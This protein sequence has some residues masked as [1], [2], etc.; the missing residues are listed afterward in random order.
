MIRIS[1][2]PDDE[3]PH[4]IL[5][6]VDKGAQDK[7]A[8][9]A[10]ALNTPRTPRGQKKRPEKIV[11]D[12]GLTVETHS[13]NKKPAAQTDGLSS[14]VSGGD[15]EVVLAQQQRTPS[16]RRR[17]QQE[18]CSDDEDEDKENQDASL[19][20]RNMFGFTPTSQRKKGVESLMKKAAAVDMDRDG[21]IAQDLVSPLRPPKTPSK[22]ATL[23]AA[24]KSGKTPVSGNI[25]GQDRTPTR[26]GETPHSLGRKSLLQDDEEGD[27]ED[28]SEEGEEM[29]RILPGTPSQ[30]PRT[31]RALAVLNN[32]NPDRSAKRRRTARILM[33]E[34]PSDGEEED[35]LEDDEDEE[36]SGGE[37]EDGA[38]DD[39]EEADANAGATYGRPSTS[40]IEDDSTGYERYFQDLHGSSK[41]SNN[42]LSKLPVLE[43]QELTDMLNA[44]PCKH[45]NEIQTLIQ[46]HEDQFPQWYFELTSGFNLLFYGYGS[47]RNLLTRFARTHLTDG[48]LLVVNGYFP[49][50]TIKEI[51]TQITSGALG[52][53]GPMGTVQEHAAFVRAYFSQPDHQRRIP[54]LYLLVHNIDGQQLRSER[55]QTALGVVASAPNVHL[56]A[57]VDHIGAALLW[58]AA[59]AARFNWVWHDGTTFDSYLVETSFEDS[60][61]VRQGEMGARGVGY[62]LTSLTDNA[63]GIFKILAEHQILES[64]GGGDGS[65]KAEDLG[66]P[67]SAYYTRAREGFFVSNDITFRTQLTEF[68]DHKI[69][70]SRRAADGSEV[71]YIPMDAETLTGVLENM[72]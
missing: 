50:I 64:L 26:K 47:K 27:Q 33:N 70:Q 29:P 24:R 56:V 32:G 5:N 44:A 48:P 55:A 37:G 28:D 12:T 21:E 10:K 43:R 46:L 62:V 57:S 15:E 34:A 54:R 20:G 1:Y 35:E 8:T 31:S 69:I 13:R 9:L 38:N 59:R 51:L 2:Q 66:L 63:R 60:I 61:M 58:D 17:Q 7:E 3:I 72:A 25:V 68:R 22:S 52:H 45:T 53:S 42:T 41:T 39:D 11:I 30:T 71:L 6:T 40:A 19:S 36:P 23:R 16:A 65:G 49:S 67:Y 14:L 18:Q 4:H